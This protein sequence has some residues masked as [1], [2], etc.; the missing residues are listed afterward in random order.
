MAAFG[1]RVSAVD[2]VATARLWGESWIIAVTLGTPALGLLSVGQRLVQVGQDLTAA[3][4][5]PV[6]TVVFARLRNSE[7]R[8]RDTYVKALGV[9]Y[10]V[11]SPMMILIVV[12]GPVLI[13]LLF[14][15]QWRPSVLPAQ[16]LAV[17]GIITLG[18]MLDHGLFYGLGRPGSW[19]SYAVIVDAATVVATAVSVRWGLTGV[20]AAFVVVAVLATVA[21]WVLVARL[22]GLEARA[23]AKP[24][25]R[26]I[27]PTAASIVLGVL[28]LNP[29]VGT[30]KVLE[31]ALIGGVTVVANLVL[32]RLLARG[33]LRDVLGVLP[34]PARYARLLA[35][36]LRMAPS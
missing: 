30:G 24:F 20:A 22:V 33:I 26:I 6:A 34:V 8:L 4:L 16:A 12:T 9:A 17:A 1:L 14:G 27:L 2:L 13:P 18:A 11:V 3:P 23:V 7:Q 15:A 28:L 19:L 32:L 21:R 10:A 5:V 29:L 31:L 35:K 36:F 25:C